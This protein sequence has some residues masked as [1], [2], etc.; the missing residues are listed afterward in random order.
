MRLGVFLPNWIGDVVMSTP[1]LRALRKYVGIEG[2][3]V[4]VMRPYVAEVLAGNAWIDQSLCYQKGPAGSTANVVRQL[5][6]ARLDAVVLLTNSLRT[7]WMAWRSGTPRRIGYA[8]DGRGWLL[9]TKLYEPRERGRWSPLPQIDSY[10]NLAYALGCE[11]EPPRLELAT[12]ADDEALA[13]D[14]WRQLGLTG[15]QVAMLNTGGAFGAAKDWPAEHF[16]SLAQRIVQTLGMHVL[17]N[18][19]PNERD[20]AREIA[21]QA[22]DPRVVSLA[23]Q[24]Q[25]PIGL[26]KACIRRA[27]LLVTTDSGP[28]FFGVAFGVPTVT[29]FGPT[30]TRWTRTHSALETSVSLGL[31]CQPCMA[32]TCPLGHHRCMRD[33]SVEMVLARVGEQLAA[34]TAQ[35]Q[36]A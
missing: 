29:L 34:V 9:T 8:R 1:T 4:G 26:T 20:T 32:R 30:S 23:D 2:R 11:W 24:P 5:R 19:G 21:R 17:V 16:S 3:V 25:L 36:A 7:A 28:R 12:T 31:Q 6:N 15:Q 18:C 27:Q 14:V 10:L 22:G 33:L 13:D 35:K